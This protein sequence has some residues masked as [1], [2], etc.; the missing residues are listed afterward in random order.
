MVGMERGRKKA[1]KD[2]IPARYL[3]VDDW[4]KRVKIAARSGCWGIARQ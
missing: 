2:G 1:V 4:K 3:E